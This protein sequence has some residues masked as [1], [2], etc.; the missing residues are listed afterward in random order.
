MHLP[1]RSGTEEEYSEREPLLQEL[2][3][4]AREFGYRF[5][6]PRKGNGAAATPARERSMTPAAARS[7]AAAAR[8]SAA[9]VLVVPGNTADFSG[10]CKE[11]GLQPLLL[12]PSGAAD[13]SGSRKETGL[14]PPLLASGLR[15]RQQQQQKSCYAD[16]ELRRCRKSSCSI[17]REWGE[18][19]P[20]RHGKGRNLPRELGSRF[21][22]PHCSERANAW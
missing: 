15:L 1:Y 3:D 22:V 19:R 14:Q 4:L 2:V 12:L 20:T 8:D 11:T 6:A 7:S 10:A 16:F 13:F 18:H 5:R 17:G 21:T 9:D